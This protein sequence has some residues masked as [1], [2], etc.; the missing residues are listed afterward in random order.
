MAFDHDFLTMMSNDFT[1]V[2]TN[3][4]HIVGHIGRIIHSDD[5]EIE[6]DR[7]GLEKSIE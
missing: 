1:T 5:R 6:F 2:E 7:E 3:I 4:D